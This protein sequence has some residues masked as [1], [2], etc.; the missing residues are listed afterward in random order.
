MSFGSSYAQIS[1]LDLNLR[2]NELA[3]YTRD[4]L[5]YST[6]AIIMQQALERV[7]TACAT[8]FFKSVMEQLLFN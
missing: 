4:N 2:I 3:A 6:R 1:S 7:P 8:A 5:L